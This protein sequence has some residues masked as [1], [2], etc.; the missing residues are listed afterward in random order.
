MVRSELIKNRHGDSCP[1]ITN[2]VFRFIA[3]IAVMDG[4][5]EKANFTLFETMGGFDV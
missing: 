4:G 1:L 2:W 3:T 5:L